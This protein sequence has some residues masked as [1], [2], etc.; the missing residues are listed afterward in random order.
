[1]Q[2]QHSKHNTCARHAINDYR[3][4]MEPPYGGAIGET[5]GAALSS[6]SMESVQTGCR[7]LAFTVVFVLKA[8]WQSG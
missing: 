8:V 1:M 2:K 6:T 4:P 3:Y 5:K 7:K